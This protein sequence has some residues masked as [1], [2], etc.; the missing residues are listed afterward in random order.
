[1]QQC[2]YRPSAKRMGWHN[3]R[4]QRYQTNMVERCDNPPR[5]VKDPPSPVQRS[6]RG[7]QNIVE[8]APFSK[9][10][11]VKRLV[12]LYLEMGEE[13]MLKRYSSEEK[14]LVVLNKLHKD[15]SV[16]VNA[17]R[18]KRKNARSFPELTFRNIP[19]LVPSK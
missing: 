3:Q 6:L 7:L 1:M 15:V 10:S 18:N 9:D 2:K 19:R 4:A 14:V 8:T 16:V 13:G 5:L 12:L 17:E 11:A